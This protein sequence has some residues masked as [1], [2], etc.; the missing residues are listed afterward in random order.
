VTASDQAAPAAPSLLAEAAAGTVA[1]GLVALLGAPIGLLWAAVAPKVEVVRTG[2][3]LDLVSSETKSFVGADGWLFVLGLLV[4]AVCGF[5]AWR[6]GRRHAL[7]TVLGLVLGSV[8]AAIIAWRVGHLV[9]VPRLSATL[10]SLPGKP[11]ID[12]TLDVRA[13][14]VLLAWPFASA[15]VFLGLLAFW[16]NRSPSSARGR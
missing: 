15:A 16:P 2:Q 4:G 7:G 5:V 9:D 3:G 1:L 14:G 12:P 10:H 13:K 6:L 11:V 8:L